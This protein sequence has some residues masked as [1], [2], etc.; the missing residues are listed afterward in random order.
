MTDQSAEYG[1]SSYG[2]Y[3]CPCCG[4][5]WRLSSNYLAC[6]NYHEQQIRMARGEQIASSGADV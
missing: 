4:L 1:A 6:L 2:P 3:V 5:L